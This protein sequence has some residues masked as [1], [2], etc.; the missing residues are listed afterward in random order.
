MPVK[1]RAV[2]FHLQG[3]LRFRLCTVDILI[4]VTEN[5][6][7]VSANVRLAKQRTKEAVK[8]KTVGNA[9]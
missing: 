8:M 3:G 2:M 9:V 6:K 1:L 7:Q 5:A 4:M